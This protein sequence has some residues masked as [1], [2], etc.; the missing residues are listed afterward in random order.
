CVVDESDVRFARGDASG[1]TWLRSAAKPFQAAA[2]LRAGVATTYALSAKD[3][4]LICASHN[5]EDRHVERARALLAR[6]GFE[7]GDLRCGA[8]PPIAPAVDRELARR[9]VAPAPLHNN[10]SGKHAGMLLLAR[11]LESDPS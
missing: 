8:H 9:G 2:A 1:A 5:S 3:V 4:A 7:E 10:C 6:G 11:V